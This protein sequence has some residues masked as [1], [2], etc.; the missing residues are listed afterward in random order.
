MMHELFKGCWEL[1]SF[2]I[3][4][5]MAIGFCIAAAIIRP[6]GH[7]WAS[8]P[9]RIRVYLSWMVWGSW[10]NKSNHLHP[11]GPKEP[12]LVFKNLRTWFMHA[13]QHIAPFLFEMECRNLKK[14][15]V[16]TNMHTVCAS[17]AAMVGWGWEL[18][19]IL[20]ICPICWYIDIIFTW[21]LN[22]WC[23]KTKWNSL[24]G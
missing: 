8:D 13:C 17:R 3:K 10:A 14:N 22:I 11:P 12:K 4:A 23:S 15:M 2:N 16:C 6:C 21:C 5:I 18:I 24:S 20:F 1:R 9:D 19:W 7:K